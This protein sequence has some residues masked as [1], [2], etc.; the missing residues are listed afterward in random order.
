MK[1]GNIYRIFFYPFFVLTTQTI[2]STN[3]FNHKVSY[4]IPVDT[5]N[6]FHI[7]SDATLPIAWTCAFHLLKNAT[8]IEER[9]EIHKPIPQA[10]FCSICDAV[11]LNP[12][13]AATNKDIEHIAHLLM[14]NPIIN[15]RIVKNEVKPIFSTTKIKAYNHNKTIT[16]ELL[17]SN[18][19]LN[20]TIGLTKQLHKTP[21]SSKEVHTMVHQTLMQ[22]EELLIT[23][24]NEM[25]R[26]P[27]PNCV[28]FACH[29][30]SRDT[31][32]VI[33]ISIVTTPDE[34]RSLY[35]FDNLNIQIQKNSQAEMFI[36]YLTNL[37]LP[38]KNS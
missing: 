5:H 34:Q 3:I 35:I 37:F 10:L 6:V 14:L 17:G 9:L 23:R 27:A 11:V 15:L 25:L 28:H 16:I 31:P 2:Y 19:P 30:I 36:R 29:L 33:L 12:R 22:R 4:P 18:T 13:K 24:I 21:P 1:K 20:E 26:S 7:H 32:H 8:S 38:E